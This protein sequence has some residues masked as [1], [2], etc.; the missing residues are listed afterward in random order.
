MSTSTKLDKDEK[1]RSVDI[2]V[3]KGLIGSLFYLTAS[4]LD[5]FSICL[6]LD[7]KPLLMNHICMRLRRLLDML[8]VRL[9]LASYPRHTSFE[10]IGYCDADFAESKI[11]R[12]SISGACQFLGHTLVS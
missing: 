10:L 11:D 12:K 6:V 7:F 4:R 5:I 1:G 8:K 9:V 3:H 2:E